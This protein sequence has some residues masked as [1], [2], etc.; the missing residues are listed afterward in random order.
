MLLLCLLLVF[1][2]AV[3]PAVAQPLTSPGAAG[4]P[5]RGLEIIPDRYIVELHPGATVDAVAHGHGVTPAVR[6]GVLHGFAAHMSHAAATALSHDAR[7][8]RVSPDVVVRAYAKPAS[9]PGKPKGGGSPAPACPTPLPVTAEQVPTGVARIAAST[10]WAAGH[11]GDGVKVAVIDTGI[12]FCHPDLAGNYLEGINYIDSSKPP[13]D[14]N[15]HGTHVSGIIAAPQNGTGVVGVAPNAKLL[16]AK[17]LDASGA[18][19]LSSIVTALDWAIQ[20]G[21]QVVNLSLGAADF[22]C[23]FGLCGAGSE[24]TAIS[25]AVAQGV[26]VV[27]AAGNSADEALF[28]TPANCQ[29]SLT[30]SALDASTDQF[31]SFSNHSIYYW[32]I[33]GSGAFTINDH[34]VVDII[35]PG[36]NVLSTMPTYDVTLTTVYGIAKNYGVLSGTSMATPHVAG[37][38]ALYISGEIISGRPAPTADQVRQALVSRGECAGSTEPA[39]GVVCSS[40]WL[41]DPDGVAEPLV[42]ASGL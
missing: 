13:R 36:V 38:A 31:A 8:R 3:T 26:V 32:D 42:D 2:L 1:G 12:D 16:A 9:P 37:A 35:A 18:G 27:V 22:W 21:A 11:K 5:S 30:V 24:C 15:G 19:S 17:V 28:Y 7:V 10:A 39:G 41:F 33:D 6:F 23:S 20:R 25:N 4:P 14:D 34:P 29:D 40:G